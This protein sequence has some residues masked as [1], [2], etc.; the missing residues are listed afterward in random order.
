M[1]TKGFFWGHLNVASWSNWKI[2]CHF[3]NECSAIIT[4][5]QTL[6]VRTRCQ[7]NT[8]K[9]R[10]LILQKVPVVNYNFATLKYRWLPIRQQPFLSLSLCATSLEW[11]KSVGKLQTWPWINNTDYR[12]E[13]TVPHWETK[14]HYVT[15]Q[16]SDC[17][18]LS[19]HKSLGQSTD[20]Y[21]LPVLVRLAVCGANLSAQLIS[22]VETGVIMG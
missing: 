6:S 10:T 21:V 7:L 8:K 9:K 20:L 4:G 18:H 13:L 11:T 22:S 1:K 3:Q 14:Q 16:H 15:R 19:E 12:E 5:A 2:K 17:A